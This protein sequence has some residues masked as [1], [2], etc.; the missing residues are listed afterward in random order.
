MILAT[1]AYDHLLCCLLTLNIHNME[2]SGVWVPTFAYFRAKHAKIYAFFRVNFH[3]CRIRVNELTDIMSAYLF[4][5]HAR[6][7][8]FHS[9][10]YPCNV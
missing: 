4:F 6:C 2:N 1:L 10:R 7:H 3:F 9:I 5:L 8:Q